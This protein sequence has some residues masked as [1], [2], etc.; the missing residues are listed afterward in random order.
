MQEKK[1]KELPALSDP[2]WR[3][4]PGRV[5]DGYWNR[6]E[7]AVRDRIRETQPVRESELV[8]HLRSYAFLAVTFGLVLGIGYGVMSLT[9]GRP[10]P[11]RNEAWDLSALVDEG[12]LNSSFVDYAYDAF[13]LKD[14][15]VLFPAG[16]M[17]DELFGSEFESGLKENELLEYLYE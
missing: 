8:H 13:E 1:H 16:E 5:P 9:G 2:V 10:V 7:D 3:Q 11:E 4:K 17:P 15:A 12:Y 6:L 14:T